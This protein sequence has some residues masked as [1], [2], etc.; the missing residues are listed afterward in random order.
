MNVVSVYCFGDDL[1][2]DELVQKFMSY[3]IKDEN[4]TEDFTPFNGHGIDVTPVIRSYILQRLLAIKGRESEVCEYLEEYLSRAQGLST[5]KKHLMSVCVLFVHCIEDVEIGKL[6]K[7]KQT[8][9]SVEI[10]MLNDILLKTQSTF[11]NGETLDIKKL[12][13]FA[14]IRAAFSELSTFINDDLFKNLETYPKLR[15]C[16]QAAKNLCENRSFLQLFLQKQLVLNDSNGLDG[17]KERCKNKELK[18][19]L[20]PQLK[21]NDKSQDNFLV[22]GENYHTVREAMNKLI[23]TSNSEEMQ[24]TLRNMTCDA[25]NQFCYILLAFYGEVKTKFPSGNEANR[26]SFEIVKK[27]ELPL[28]KNLLE[29]FKES[30]YKQLLHLQPEEENANVRRLND[31]LIHFLVVMSC[32]PNN[33]LLGPFS[34]LAFN[35]RS[36]R[37]AFIPTMPHMMVLRSL[38]MVIVHRMKALTDIAMVTKRIIH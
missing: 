24:L 4:V 15:E 37:N 7:A 23:I 14:L 31:I 17:A 35:P 32:F 29:N 33:Q 12:K 13:D 11:C 5:N 26:I 28:A 27:L 10:Q 21:E 18:W 36:M 25:Q 22:H 1:P 9:S 34:N 30:P 16:I 38:T 6:L 20:P 19:I 3:V 8:E 2:Q